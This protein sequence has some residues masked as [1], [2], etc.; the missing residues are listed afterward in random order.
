MLAPRLAM[1]PAHAASGTAVE[2]AKRALAGD[3]GSAGPLAQQSGDSAAIKLVEL[4]YLKD[5]GSEAGY[6]RVMA[7]V[8]GAP[9]WPLNETLLRRA[10]KA[11]YDN[12]E[13]PAVVSQHFAARKPATAYGALV[14]ARLA[15]ASGD[16]ASGKAWLSKAWADPD[17]DVALE[18]KITSEFGSR[19]SVDDHKKRLWQLIFDQKGESAVRVAKTYLGGE[20]VN[21]AN[22][23]R[24]LINS[25]GGADKK[26]GSLSG[27]MRNQ[28][29]LLYVLTRYYRKKENFSGARSVL[30]SIPGDPV[31][32]GNADAW[33]DERRTSVRR[34][35]G[36]MQ[37]ANWKTA[38]L[39]AK[40]HGMVKGEGAIDSEF[41]AG[42]VALRYLNQPQVAMG[43]FLKLQKLATNGTE[44]ARAAYWI[45]RSQLALGNQAQA[46]AAFKNA[47]SHTTVYYGQLARE[48][49]GLGKKPEEITPAA[50]SDAAK[51]SVARDELVRGA[52]LLAQ[53]GGQNKMG[54]FLMPLAKRFENTDQLNAVANMLQSQVGVACALRFA[55]ASAMQGKDIDAWGYPIYGLPNWAQVGKPIEKSMVFALSRQE[56]EFDPNAG[57]SVGAQGLM[58]LMPG[59]AKM[60]AKQYGIGYNAGKLKDAQYNVKL[61]AAHLA[62][63]VDNLNG[64]YVLTLVAYNAGPRRA[65]DWVSYFGDPRGGKVDAVDWVECIP[66]NETRQY[67]QKVMQNLHVYRSRL[68]PETVRPMTADLRRGNA[69]DVNVASTGAVQ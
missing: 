5:H 31:A 19:L 45:G 14:M 11:L 30:A 60:V 24:A 33:S 3:F 48:E 63:L 9:D 58:Q 26:F 42:W 15:Y 36:P 40:N 4:F 25:E 28:M 10:E 21:A 65:T 41:L 7:F 34:S 20:Y 51:A 43:H 27:A 54:I 2:A 56:S 55:K 29:A 37:R 44:G 66:F 53:A 52:S 47:A 62:D 49:I 57:S 6:D 18:K 32:M 64:S 13:S 69:D 8:N 22:V 46:K 16:G 1:E 23:G 35:V 68:A 17:V 39:I 59:T 61:G 38:Y 67:V 12:S 50:S